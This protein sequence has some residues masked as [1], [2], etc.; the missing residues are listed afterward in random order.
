MA[1]ILPNLIL[2][3]H[4]CDRSVGEDILSDKGEKHLRFSQNEYDW[5]G[6][7]IYFWENSFERAMLFAT[8]AKNRPEL[9]QGEIKEPFVVG[10]VIFLGLCLNLTDYGEI[11]ALKEA[12]EMLE[13]SGKELPENEAYEHGV[14]LKRKLDCAVVETLRELR[15]ERAL[16]PFDTVRGLFIEGDKVY[17]GAGFRELSHIQICVREPDKCIKGYFRPQE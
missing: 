7:G 2:A 14:P 9:T 11:D 15:E 17:P 13:L 4:G 1:S 16:E 10:A 6:N 3:Y 5:L 12:Y 8:Q